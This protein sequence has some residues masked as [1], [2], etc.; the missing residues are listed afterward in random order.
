MCKWR[1]FNIKITL[2]LVHCY[3][4]ICIHVHTLDTA[5]DPGSDVTA[6]TGR[7]SLSISTTDC[8]L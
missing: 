7:A 8:Q 1:Y 5:D 3:M 6:G 2:H 4:C